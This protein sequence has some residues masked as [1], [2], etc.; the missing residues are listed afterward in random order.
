MEPAAEIT[1]PRRADR[2]PTGS[3]FGPIESCSRSRPGG[4]WFLPVFFLLALLLL[5]GLALGATS[6]T[7]HAPAPYSVVKVGAPPTPPV[8][9][10]A[11]ADAVATRGEAGL[12]AAGVQTAVPGMA[13]TPTALPGCGAADCRDRYI[14][15]SPAGL[16][17]GDYAER[18]TYT[19]T[20]PAAG[21]T[22]FMIEL[23]VELSTGWV[24]GRAYLA[25]GT[26][27]V[28]GGSTITLELYLNLD[29]AAAPDILSV[30]SVIDA[31]TSATACP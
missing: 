29:T 3:R 21:S 6:V 13:G 20:Q 1:E 28:A 22:G 2:H 25:T 8:T 7:V 24:V 30:Q 15:A 17:A 9:L 11:T 19:V 10:T 18:G 23:A 26:S 14:V 5:Q 4:L 27:G 12:G 16:T 31:C